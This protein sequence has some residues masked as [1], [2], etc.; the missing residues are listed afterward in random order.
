MQ[1]P[2]MIE[3]EGY[4]K[5][6]KLPNGWVDRSHPRPSMMGPY[7]KNYGPEN[8]DKVRLSFFDRGR[9]LSETGALALSALLSKPAGALSTNDLRSIG[10]VLRDA[11]IVDEFNFLNARTEV[12]NGRPVVVI[13]GRWAQLQ[14][15][16]LWLIAA[17]STCQWIYEVMYQAPKSEYPMYLKQVRDCLKTIEWK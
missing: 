7:W 12:F 10:E 16:R 15:D 6:M 14:E 8:K 11:A 17:D 13:E 9:P 4:V 5:T 2:T 3:E 1:A